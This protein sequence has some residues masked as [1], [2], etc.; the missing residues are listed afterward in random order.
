MR[1]IS[2]DGC[3]D[4]EYEGN[5]FSILQDEENEKYTVAIRNASMTGYMELA[6]YNSLDVAKENFKKMNQAYEDF[7]TET[8]H[9][10]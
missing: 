6:T 7:T 9:F 4:V 1:I 5:V 8:F 3:L 10:D 2:Q